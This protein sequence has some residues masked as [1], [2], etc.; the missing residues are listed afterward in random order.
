MKQVGR[1][2]PPNQ[3][4]PLPIGRGEY[5]IWEYLNAILCLRIEAIAETKAMGGLHILD[6]TFFG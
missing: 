1:W 3:F 5:N 2:G 4:C 6:G